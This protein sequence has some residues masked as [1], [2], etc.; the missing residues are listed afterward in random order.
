[1]EAD[2]YPAQDISDIF[3]QQHPTDLRYSSTEYTPV[4]P[5]NSLTNARTINF[6]L[7]GFTGSGCLK[8]NE[9]IL[10]L[11]MKLTK[12]DNTKIPNG[13]SVAPC[14]LPLHSVFKSCSLYLNDQLVNNSSDLYA[15][16]AYFLTVLSY[17]ADSRYGFL[18]GA[19]CYPDTAGFL[20]DPALN[21][22][23]TSRMNLFKK[24]PTSQEYHGEE[25]QF[26]SRL[27][28]DLVTSDCPVPPGVS[29]RVV[30]TLASSDFVL[31]VPAE[32]NGKYKFSLSDVVLHIP[33]AAMSPE[34]YA[35]FERKLNEKEASIYFK[36]FE[37]ITKCIPK[38]TT[39]Y[40][41]ETLFSQQANPCKLIAAVVETSAFVG[42][43]KK[44][45]F[46]FKRSFG[47]GDNACFIEY[48]DLLLNSK[49]LD[50]LCGRATERDDML[51]FIRLQH[52]LQAD[53]N[54]SAN[55]ISY[56]DFLKG[57][58]MGVYDIST[59]GQCG[60]D[61]LSPATRMGSLRLTIEF[62]K[63]CP[64]ELTVILFSEFPSLININY[65]MQSAM[66]YYCGVI[67]TVATTE[68]I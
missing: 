45:P 59:S 4:F 42:N 65:H 23:F 24:S 25:V 40:N 44:N 34:V 12:E 9:S 17:G 15:Y 36:R 21:S 63:P 2:S 16:K 33:V 5:T 22:G 6:H 52:F 39:V 55:N 26:A 20:D 66:G 48:M 14:N 46:N 7:S 56:Q 62:S 27:F 37:M 1:M 31:Q 29:V 8:L 38:N 47:S 19:G 53:N 49:T 35:R 60:F 41:S 50:G 61:F 68:I 58:Y 11:K 10:A 54:E 67:T 3:F 32:D 64:E 28:L 30:L 13:K 57:T 43:F 18:Q 51:K